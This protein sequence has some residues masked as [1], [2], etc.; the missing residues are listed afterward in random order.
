MSGKVWQSPWDHRDGSGLFFNR[1]CLYYENTSISQRMHTFLR[2]CYYCFLFSCHD[3][4]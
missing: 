4:V 2:A 3:E 1:A